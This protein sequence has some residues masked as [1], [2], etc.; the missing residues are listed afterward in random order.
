MK[1]RD[2]TLT[3]SIVDK[4]P[5]SLRTVDY[6]TYSMSRSVTGSLSRPITSEFLCLC[7]EEIR[8][9][10]SEAES[11]RGKTDGLAGRERNEG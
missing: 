4:K 6:S 3:L 1:E 9:A 11:G 10:E 7:G 2:L 8:G 5:P